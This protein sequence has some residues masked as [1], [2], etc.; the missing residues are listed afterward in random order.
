MKA[1][2]LF[3]TLFVALFGFVSKIQ[4]QDMIKF[5]DYYQSEGFVTGTIKCTQ[6]CTVEFYLSA[7]GNS[8]FTY[9]FTVAGKTITTPGTQKV[10]VDLKP[11]NNHVWIHIFGP[12]R[13]L[14]Q[15]EGAHAYIDIFR[16]L[17]GAQIGYHYERLSLD[18][19]MGYWR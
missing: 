3:I 8:C 1:K 2:I 18:C 4:A 19:T 11:G 10:V 5:E 17:S 14:T 16:V 15:Y 7:V 9:S 12:G 13:P 6:P